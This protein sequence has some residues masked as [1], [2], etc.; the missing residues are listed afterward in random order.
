MA[1]GIYTGKF[2][3]EQSGT[4]K[5]PITLQGSSKAVIDNPGRDGLSLTGAS[6]WILD[7]IG[8]VGCVITIQFYSNLKFKDL[9]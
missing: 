7:G 4:A 5:N 2:Q 3:S 8:L 9:Q 6:W 1:D